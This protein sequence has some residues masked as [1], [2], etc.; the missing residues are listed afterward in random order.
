MKKIK[1]IV[2][3]LMMISISA[4]LS[5]LHVIC[6]GLENAEVE[7]VIE[8]EKIAETAEK[9]KKKEEVDVK[10]AIKPEPVEE[11]VYIKHITQEY[12]MAYDEYLEAEKQKEIKKKRDAIGGEEEIEKLYRIVMAEAGDQG[13][14]G[15]ELVASVVINRMR[16]DRYPDTISE[17]ITEK[18]QFEP[19]SNG[20]YYTVKPTKEVINAVD[21]V[22]E[23]GIVTNALY[24][25][26]PKLCNAS[27]TD[28]LTYVTTY[29]DHV[30]YK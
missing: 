30:F 3:V 24:F 20:K 16:S 21:K 8:K 18:H 9:T 19:V 10:E 17:V 1:A 12:V 29:K 14:Y 27:W 5:P 26:N 6:K 7:K 13:S 23:E 15:Q 11:P 28:E 22:V 25:L 4:Y 2:I